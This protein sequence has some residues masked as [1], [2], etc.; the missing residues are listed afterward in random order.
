MLF[1][2]IINNDNNDNY[3]NKCH[4]CGYAVKWFCV[5]NGLS[6]AV[7]VCSDFTSCSC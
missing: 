1:K 4:L 5:E 6:A 2:L 3:S 7:A